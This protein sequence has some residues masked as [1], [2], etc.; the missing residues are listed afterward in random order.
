MTEISRWGT[1]PKAISDESRVP[2]P[3]P[4]HSIVSVRDLEQTPT[5]EEGLNNPF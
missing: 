5:V 4:W 3:L 1:N 2:E